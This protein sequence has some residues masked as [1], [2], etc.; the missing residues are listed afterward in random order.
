MNLNTRPNTLAQAAREYASLSVREAARRSRISE[1]YL[2]RIERSG[3]APYFLARR[4]SAIYNCGLDAFLP[5]KSRE[6][7]EGS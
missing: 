6:E 5:K 3:S 4:L 7:V 2:R 1:A